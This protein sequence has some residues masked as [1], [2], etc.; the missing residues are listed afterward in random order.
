[1]TE[2][3]PIRMVVAAGERPRWWLGD[4]EITDVIVDWRI[5]RADD[6]LAEVQ[7]TLA[8]DLEMLIAGAGVDVLVKVDS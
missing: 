2:R 6:G 3:R 8:A 1:V 5:T 7:V 4:E